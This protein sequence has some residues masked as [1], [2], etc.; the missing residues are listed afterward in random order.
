LQ[1]QDQQKST[2]AVSGFAPLAVGQSGG[3]FR[4]HIPIMVIRILTVLFLILP[5][6]P[7]VIMAQNATQPPAPGDPLTGSGDVLRTALT[8]NQLLN[9]FSYTSP[10]N[11]S[12]LALPEQ[13]AH[14][15]LTFEGRLELLDEATSGDY[16]II[17]DDYDY[18]N[19]PQRFHLPEFNFQFVQHGS[20]LIPVQ[21]GRIVTGHP[22]WDYLLSPGRVWHE[23]D[24][25]DYMRAAIP[26]ALLQKNQN[27]THNGT[28]MFLF[29]DGEVSNVWYQITQETCPYFKTDMWGLLPAIY[30][31]ASVSDADNLRNDFVKE[32]EDRIPIKPIAALTEV[33]PDVDLSSFGAGLTSEH[34]SVYGLMADGVNYVGPCRT[35]YG[36]Y[37]YCEAMRHASY[38][39]AKSAFAA[40]ALMRLAQQDGLDV[41]DLLIKDYVPEAASAS[42]D[43]DN[44]TFENA[45]DMATGNYESVEYMED[46]EGTTMSAFFNAETYNAKISAA[47]S[48]PNKTAPGQNWVY[49]TSDTFILV[50][51]LQNYLDE[52]VFDWLVQ[53]VFEPLKIGPGAY[54]SARTS[55]NNWQGQAF[56]GYGL[57]WTVDDAAKL[58]EVMQHR[59]RTLDGDQL[60]HPDLV[61]QAM[62]RT[63]E[64]GFLTGV[65]EYYQLG[66]WASKFTPEVDSEFQCT[67][68][69]PY[70]SGNG[71]IT[72][73]LLPN[74]MTY[75]Y[76][77]DNGEFVWLDAVKETYRMRSHCLFPANI[78]HSGDDV[79]LSWSAE[80]L[81]ARY[82]IWRSEQPDF[83]PGDADATMIH[84]VANT[85]DELTYTDP[86]HCGDPDINY[87]YRIEALDEEDLR[88]GLTGVLGEFDYLLTPGL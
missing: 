36:D 31:P 26:F 35:R 70:M 80:G 16:Q 21:R 7:S 64:R 42:G 72:I 14:P 78:D 20:H 34:V 47:F 66:F 73:L 12:A 59:G 24:D 27:C 61:A 55:E 82:R 2:P 81:H 54:S 85:A 46:E 19:D 18:A 38:S 37:G 68:Y 75:Y 8:A 79:V 15:S 84:E 52:D 88:V 44:V 22:Y 48:Y 3:G 11:E 63:A 17:R 58:A 10:E 69:T 33:Y 77:S 4:F 30:H 43:W 74:G 6:P 23:N 49:H 87:Y 5:L 86:D 53:Q 56:G 1:Q 62:Q 83:M 41:K 39:T 57:W 45:L 32:L 51:A 67:F 50:R 76:F 65:D 13:A 28:L 9:G 60:L 29:R 71:G 25:G 40:M